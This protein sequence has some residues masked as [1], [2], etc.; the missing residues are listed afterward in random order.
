[1]ILNKP[2][3]YGSPQK[4]HKN[5]YFKKTFYLEK[6]CLQNVKNLA[7]S[8]VTVVTLTSYLLDFSSR[9]L[10]WSYVVFNLKRF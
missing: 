8:M 9:Q 4:H 10:D 5:A 7:F 6:I 3:D 1:V 2:R